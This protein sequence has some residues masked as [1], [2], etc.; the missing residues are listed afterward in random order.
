MK[1][2]HLNDKIMNQWL[3]NRLNEITPDYQPNPEYSFKATIY[4]MQALSL[5]VKKEAF[6]DEN[7]NEFYKEV[8]RRSPSFLA[9]T[10]VFENLL[11]ALHNLASLQHTNQDVKKKYNVVRSAIV[12]WYYVL[13]RAR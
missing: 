6:Q 3:L 7:L 12:D 8:P 1:S 4:W 11:L 2:D 10:Y 9:D 5:L 13:H